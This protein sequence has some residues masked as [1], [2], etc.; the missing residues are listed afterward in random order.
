MVLRQPKKH[1]K[2]DMSQKSSTSSFLVISRRSWT[3]GLTPQ[4]LHLDSSEQNPA[5]APSS[6][7][8]RG[9]WQLEALIVS[10]S[11]SGSAWFR[12]EPK[13]WSVLPLGTG[14]SATGSLEYVWYVMYIAV[15]TTIPARVYGYHASFQAVLVGST[16][17][18]V[19]IGTFVA[20]H[21]AERASRERYSG[22]GTKM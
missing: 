15:R 6:Q 16:T 19:V 5:P 13:P 18:A 10:A 14:T 22:K 12:A 9:G 2:C 3:H 7:G 20:T 17:I 1:S 21:F 11:S 8:R 4:L